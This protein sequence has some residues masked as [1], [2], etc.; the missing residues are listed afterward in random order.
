MGISVFK[1]IA[2]NKK[3]C[4]S[5]N[6]NS[7]NSASSLALINPERFY[8]LYT[9]IFTLKSSKTLVE[10]ISNQPDVVALF[11]VLSLRHSG[12]TSTSYSAIESKYKIYSVACRKL[13]LKNLSLEEESQL[14]AMKKILTN[15]NNVKQKSIFDTL[16]LNV[17]VLTNNILDNSNV[18]LI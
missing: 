18:I 3:L 4:N 12:T 9:Y 15:V 5:L 17:N 14:L 7:L 1:A 16:Y 2:M 6:L 13:R 11:D 8:N 10:W